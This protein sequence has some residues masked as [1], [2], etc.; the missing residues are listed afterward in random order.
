MT[1]ETE[2]ACLTPAEAKALLKAV[3]WYVRH[4][5]NALLEVDGGA[6]LAAQRKLLAAARG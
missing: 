1:G 6:L 2:V 4:G 3:T 5:P